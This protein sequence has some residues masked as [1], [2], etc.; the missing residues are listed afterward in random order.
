ML[1]LQL[2]DVEAEPLHSELEEEIEDRVRVIERVR[3]DHRNDVEVDAAPP[4]DLDAFHYSGVC[5]FPKSVFAM[6]IVDGRRPVNADADANGMLR[7]E[8][9]P[10]IR[11]RHPIGLNRVANAI[12]RDAHRVDFR[13]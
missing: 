8:V 3:G 4:Q 1:A 13:E 5:A 2:L 10:A 7:D 9:A 6:P 12:V 11:H